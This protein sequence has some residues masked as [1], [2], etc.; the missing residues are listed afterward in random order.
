ML[1]FSAFIF[2]PLA[3]PSLQQLSHSPFRA[4]LANR[5]TLQGSL[6]ALPANASGTG[7]KYK[8]T[9]ARAKHSKAKVMIGIV[10]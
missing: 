1:P 8:S 4:D 6:D 2:S 10:L 7:E 3:R 5:N 9:A